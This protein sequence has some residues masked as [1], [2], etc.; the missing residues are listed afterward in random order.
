MEEFLT[1]EPNKKDKSSLNYFIYNFG[2]EEGTKKYKERCFLV[3]ERTKKAMETLGMSEKI[4]EATKNGQK[5]NNAYEKMSLKSIDRWK[6]N[7]YRDKVIKSKN[8]SE[9]FQKFLFSEENP[10]VNGNAGRK[11][12]SKNPECFKILHTKESKQLRQNSQNLIVW[13]RIKNQSEIKPVFELKDFGKFDIYKWKCLKC[14]DEIETKD[15]RYVPFC[16]K[17]NEVFNGQSFCEQELQNY[18][19]E[20]YKIERNKRFFEDG[21]YKYQLDIYIPDLNLGIEYDGLYWHS[22][23]I[24]KDKFNCFLKQMYFK[25]KGIRTI[26]IWENEWLYKK[27]IVK[28]FLLS[29]I[30]K[31]ENKI[32]AKQCIVKEVEYKMSIEFLKNNHIQGKCQFSESV[33][34]FFKNELV[35]IMTFSHNNTMNYEWELSRF[36]SKLGFSVVGGFS[37]LLKYFELKIKPNFLVSF[38]N[39]RIS[40]GNVYYK[41]GFELVGLIEPDYFYI[42]KNTILSH[43]QNYRKENIKEKF[44]ERYEECLTEW[45]NMKNLGYNRIWDC[46]KLKFIKEFK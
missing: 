3:K 18:I 4:S 2:I 23:L 1:K 33:G 6:D 46:G 15:Y 29:K 42:E 32:Y 5:E 16:Y 20:F 40:D 28:S 10:F 38:S 9:K 31:I 36:C 25:N 11:S 41:N 35:S 37:R 26:H 45:E 43:K 21:K 22:E 14:K 17:C 7:S 19:S 8:E 39:N 34:L 12:Q 30:N 44:P 24:H 27:E 13:E